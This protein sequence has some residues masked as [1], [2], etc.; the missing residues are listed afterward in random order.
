MKPHHTL[1]LYNGSSVTVYKSSPAFGESAQAISV[2]FDGRPTA[3]WKPG[4][5]TDDSSLGVRTNQFGFNLS[6]AGGMAVAVG[7][8]TNPANPVWTPLQTNMPTG[9]MLYFSDP[10]WTNHPACFYRLR[11]P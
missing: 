10:R 1:Q 3:L 9:D 5:L 2:S 6:W 11:W 4:I 7:A 8:C